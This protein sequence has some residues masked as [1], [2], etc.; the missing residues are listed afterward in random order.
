MSRESIE[1]LSDFNA[2]TAYISPN[3]QKW[4]TLASEYETTKCN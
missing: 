4:E 1:G 2:V 3:V